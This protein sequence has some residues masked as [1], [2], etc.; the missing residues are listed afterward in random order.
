MK[1]YTLR[2]EQ[3]LPIA[4]DEAWKFFSDPR[5]LAKITPASMNFRLTSELSDAF[6][7]GMIITYRV[8]PLAGVPITWVTE[9]T[10]VDAPHYF[11]D[12]QRF[13]PYRFWHHQHLFREIPGGVEAR[14]VVHYALPRAAGPFG[15]MAD[16]WIVR[17]QLSRIFGFRR[18]A[19][20]ER[21]GR[22]P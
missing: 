7:G 3:R 4:M 15:W 21:F 2:A 18:A 12:E 20:E 1:I 5:N 22:M 17:R 6:Y 10:H 19:L 8:S 11:V 13:G 16:R 9:I 14:D